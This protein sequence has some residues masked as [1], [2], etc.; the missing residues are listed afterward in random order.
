MNIACYDASNFF[1]ALTRALGVGDIV[2]LTRLI[3]KEGDDLQT[4][5][6]IYIGDENS[7]CTD[8]YQFKEHQYPISNNVVFEPTFVACNPLDPSKLNGKPENDYLNT[9]FTNYNFN[10][11]ELKEFDLKLK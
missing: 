10:N 6:V 3:K 2:E 9:L 11:C 1:T 8:V 7:A 5:H 4:I